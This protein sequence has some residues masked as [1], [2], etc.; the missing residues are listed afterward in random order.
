LTTVNPFKAAIASRQQE[1]T[2]KPPVINNQVLKV[3]KDAESGAESEP[4]P[5]KRK[6]GRPP[7]TRSATDP[8]RIYIKPGRKPAKDLV[9]VG[10]PATGKRSNES[11]TGRTYYVELATDL[12]VQEQLLQLK[13]EGHD[14]D[15][16][17]LVN[18]LLAAWVSLRKNENADFHII[19]NPPRLN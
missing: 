16:S 19:E 13:R 15:K 18:A 11:W 6:R 1:E 8:S 14:L 4:A 17:E 7:G 10:R 9:K 2:I 5:T 12:N 3:I